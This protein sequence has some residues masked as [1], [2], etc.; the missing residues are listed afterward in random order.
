MLP[1]KP[2]LTVLPCS[3][4]CGPEQ[5]HASTIAPVSLLVNPVWLKCPP[6]RF[7]DGLH[8][9]AEVGFCDAVLDGSRL[10]MLGKEHTRSVARSWRS[11]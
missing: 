2:T 1:P 4:V 5:R 8:F 10:F 3:L 6:R 9:R 7:Q 11:V